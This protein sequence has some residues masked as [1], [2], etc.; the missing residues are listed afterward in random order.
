MLKKRKQNKNEIIENP[1]VSKGT[2]IVITIVMTLLA[3]AFLFPIF[4]V[5]MN[6][7]KNKLY[8]SDAPFAL[9]NSDTFSGMYNYVNGIQK[10]G[11]LVAAG[12]SAF[13][14]ICSV[15]VIVLLTSMAAWWITR[16][17]CKLSTVLYYLF[18]FAMIVPFQMV[19]FT[20]SKVTDFLHLGNMFG[21]IPVYLGFGAGLSLLLPEK[22]E[23][24]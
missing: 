6:S 3:V 5:L 23:S 10:T 20:L 19:M 18:V 12:R 1:A 11:L 9:P 15:I 17:T 21:I 2:G 4:L 16:V 24:P 22:S 7:F 8:I 13:I 14:T